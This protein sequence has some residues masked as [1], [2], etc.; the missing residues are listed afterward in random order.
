ML[1]DHDALPV[2]FAWVASYFWKFPETAWR[3]RMSR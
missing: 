1:D 3:R 2:I